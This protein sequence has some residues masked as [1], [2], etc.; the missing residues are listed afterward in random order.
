MNTES[1]ESPFLA[2]YTAWIA[3]SDAATEAEYELL[4]SRP[5]D[6][7]AAEAKVLPLWA[8][9]D[10]AHEAWR[11]AHAFDSDDG[12]GCDDFPEPDEA[13]EWASFDPDC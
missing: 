11:E 9:A 10:A 2:A 3:A 1:P 13:Q 6:K 7:A 5:C 8:A 12:E 4:V